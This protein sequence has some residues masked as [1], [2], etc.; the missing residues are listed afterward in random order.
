MGYFLDKKLS[1][2]AVESIASKIWGPLGL[3]EVLSN[4]KGFSFLCS[5]LGRI[6]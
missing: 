5:N 3:Q 1:F 2:K 6:F 4:D